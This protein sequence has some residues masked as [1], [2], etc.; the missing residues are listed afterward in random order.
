M[1]NILDEFKERGLVKQI[2][3][4]EELHDL[5]DEEKVVCYMGFD[6]SADSLQ[7]GNIAALCM[8]L[9]MQKA[10]HKPIALIG[11]ATGKIGD[12]TGRNDMRP[13]KTEEQLKHNIE[14]ITKQIKDF[15]KLNGTEDITIVNNDDW[16]SK[17]SYYDFLN[18]IAMHMSVNRML[19]SECFKARMENGLTLAE[20]AYMPM[21]ANDFLHLFK[22][23]N[24][25][26]EL[27]GDDQWA[28][29]IAGVELVRKKE[30]APVFAIT[31][32]LL[33][34]ADGT[35]MGKSA[36][37]AVWVSSEKTSDYDFYQFFR[38]TEDVK[39]KEMF[40]VLTLLPLDEIEEI[41][42]GEGRAL[43]VA[44]ERLAYEVTKLIRG[45]AS[46]KKA[47]EMARA[48]FGGSV[49][50]MQAVEIKRE[51]ITTILDLLTELK[52]ANS[53]GEAKRLVDGKGIRIDD[54][55]VENYDFPII[56]EQFVLQKGKKGIQKVKL[57]W[58]KH[59]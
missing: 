31:L 1:A 34:K 30:R 17:L 19:A 15:F 4:E 36:G 43:N 28:N 18:N 16:T 44:K 33:T 45:E 58:W 22:K 35:K 20:F 37:G 13:Q 23:Y 39:V 46:A 52:M 49:E 56:K 11:G 24:C 53:R 9:R 6:P 48:N 47:Q 26:L 5:L 59:F 12:P 3:Y 54:E 32:P 7:M 21:Q 25:V 14:C 41:C 42:R 38:N 29:I 55:V 40:K 10:G 2:I 50:E 51:N 57:V 27:G 8:L